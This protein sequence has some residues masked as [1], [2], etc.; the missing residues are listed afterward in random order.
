MP[1]TIL[2]HDMSEPTGDW[3]NWIITT[4]FAALSTM[5]GTVVA[6]AKMIESKYVQEIRDLKNEL[7]KFESR[8]SSEIATLKEDSRACQEDRFKLSARV[9]QLEAMQE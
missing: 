7:T 3:S 8:S 1:P 2:E 5:I 9:A 6:L 4:L